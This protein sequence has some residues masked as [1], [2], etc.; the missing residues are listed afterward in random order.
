MNEGSRAG[1]DLFVVCCIE[2]G[3]QFLGKERAHRPYCKVE[4]MMGGSGKMVD[5]V[6]DKRD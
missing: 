5:D 2:V 6:V 3:V 4:V 1:M